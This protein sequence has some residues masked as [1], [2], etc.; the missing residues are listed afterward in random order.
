MQDNL[1][2]TSDDDDDDKKS[3]VKH[4]YNL[5]TRREKSVQEL[6]AIAKR[7]LISKKRWDTMLK[8]KEIRH[9]RWLDETKERERKEKEYDEKLKTGWE[10]YEGYNFIHRCHMCKLKKYDVIDYEDCD[11]SGCRGQR[12]CFKCFRNPLNLIQ[13]RGN[14]SIST[15]HEFLNKL[16]LVSID[17]NGCSKVADHPQE[18]WQQDFSKTTKKYIGPLK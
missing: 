11:D 8:N 5:R 17:Q 7:K 12:Y 3:K 16:Y 10:P 14:F 6:Q 1:C 18:E 4:N 15:H 13:N 2:V 9:Q